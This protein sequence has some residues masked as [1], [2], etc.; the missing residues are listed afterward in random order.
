MISGAMIAEIAALAGDPARANILTALLDGRAMTATELA[1]AA[2]VTPQTTSAH[3][4]KL[5][6][7]GLIT[8]T[9]S[10]RHR[11]FRLASPKVAQMLESIVAVAGDNRPRFRPLSR[12]AVALQA[13]RM[14]Y[15]HIAG[16]LGVRIAEAMTA[17]GYL[18]LEDDGGRMT[19]TGLRYLW[20]LGID[21]RVAGKGRR[22]LC[23]A[24]LDWTERRPHVGG[25]IGAAL[26]ERWLT[27][28]WI[29]RTKD[30]RAITV[31]ADGERGFRD[32]LGLV[33]TDD[34]KAVA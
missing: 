17:R 32:T 9:P 19:E 11:Y 16:Q 4:A 2:R 27:L 20:E 12:Q 33:L 34:E 13:A 21:T 23:R 30:S 3:L 10:G 31:T 24:C 28:G 6:D 29:A 8:A 1:Y 5:T 18:V 25:A 14:C 26:A 7:A 15:D 22:H